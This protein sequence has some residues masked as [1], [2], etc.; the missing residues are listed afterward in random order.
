VP[1]L[2]SP[3]AV[4]KLLRQYALAHQPSLFLAE[5]LVPVVIVDD[6]SGAD[7]ANQGFPRDAMGISVV[8]AGGAG[9]VSVATWIPT[10]NVLA[11]LT[12]IILQNNAADRTYSIRNLGGA[13]VL[14]LVARTTKDFQD[15][16]LGGA[17]PNVQ[18]AVRNDTALSDGNINLSVSVL[19]DDTVLIPCSFV[20]F[21]GGG[22][23]VHHQDLNTALEVG[24]IWTEYLI[25]E[26]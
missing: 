23:Q 5:E 8:G 16:R 4:Q 25:T 11:K 15:T 6:L 26:R 13:T 10:N 9:N 19:A 21:N 14:G 18:I 3:E 7:V 17:P 2:Q 24:W 20:G 1:D 12:G 22:V